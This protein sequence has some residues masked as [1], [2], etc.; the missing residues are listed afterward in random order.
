VVRGTGRGDA[1]APHRGTVASWSALADGARLSGVVRSP[2]SSPCSASL[3]TASA[4]LLAVA[5]L[6]APSAVPPSPT[7]PSPPTLPAPPP[8]SP[9]RPA[10]P[11]SPPLSPCSAVPAVT[12][13]T[14][15]LAG[16]PP[17][18]RTLAAGEVDAYEIEL[19]AGEY[20]HLRVEQLQLDVAIAVFAPGHRRLFCADSPN[21]PNGPEEVH[22][23]ADSSGR[24]RLEVKGVAAGRS[25]AYR[26]QLVVRRPARAADHDRFEAQMAARQATETGDDAAGFWEAAAKDEKAMRGLQRPDDR[27]AAAAIAYQL[28]QL[29]F[30]HAFYRDA[31]RLY[32]QYL[33]LS[34]AL[35]RR[36]EQG[37]ALNEIGQ[38][39]T[40]L[41]EPA[42]ALAAFRRAL[43]IWRQERIPKEE[44]STLINVAVLLSYHGQ[45]WEALN[46][47]ER[48][49]DLA[50]QLRDGQSEVNALNGVGMVHAM[51]GDFRR[52]RDAHLAA[53]RRLNQI[54]ERPSQQVT[55][56]FLAVAASASGDPRQALALLGQSLTLVK[57][58]DAESLRLRAVIENTIGVSQMRLHDDEAALASFGSA[59]ALFQ[60]LGLA[61][62]EAG[63]RGNIGRA[64]RQL[65]RLPAAEA[66]FRAALDRG[67]LLHDRRLEATGQLGLAEVL[68][69]GAQPED[70]LRI[71]EQGLETV[72]SLRSGAVRADL[73]TSYLAGQEELFDVVIESLMA[74]HDRQPVAGGLVH[75]ALARSEERRARRLLDELVRNRLRD[76]RRAPVAAIGAQLVKTVA[77]IDELDL[78]QRRIG[79]TAE[80]QAAIGKA[81]REKLEAASELEA[82]AAL[83]AVPVGGASPAPPRLPTP[84]TLPTLPTPPTLPTLPRLPTL[85]TPPTPPA[86]PAA[87]LGADSLLL[88]YHLAEPRSFLW[89]LAGDGR[90][91]SFELPGRQVIEERVR[92]VYA[93]DAH[94]GNAAPDWFAAG[95]ERGARLAKELGQTLLGQAASL[96]GEKRL[97]IAADG[98]LQYLPFAAL[99]D[100]DGSGNPLVVRH[101]L[102]AIPSLAVLAE[103]R[104]RAAARTPPARE[105]PAADELPRLAGTAT[106]AA[107][108]LAL[109]PGAR[110][111][112][113]SGFAAT[114]EAVTRGDLAGYRILHFAT[115]GDA[116]PQ[117][118][119]LSAIA[120]SRYDAHGTPRDG[121]LR[122]QALARLRLPADLVVLSACATAL[123]PEVERE[124]MFGLPQ[125]FLAAGATRVLVSLWNVGDRSTAELMRRFYCHLLAGGLPADA[126]LRRAQLEMWRQPRWR[127]PFYWAGFVLQGD[128][129]PPPGGRAG[130]AAGVA[131]GGAGG[132]RCDG[133]PAA[134]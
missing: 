39:Y 6:T 124:G 55:L 25:G 122:A 129:Q 93:I 95:G 133:E 116:L 26:E 101:S 92:A 46:T 102:V 64:D 107:A 118:S 59:L 17:Q 24:Y 78:A 120:L 21:G 32:Q 109:A 22:L 99:P 105:R 50:R 72:E 62:E 80:E 15:A 14:L 90:V 67:H 115:H 37:V 132:A 34:T 49:R 43:A 73:Q 48:A 103:L 81:L 86:L 12:V 126:A 44:V 7:P 71:A 77:E 27:A 53:L 98:I 56:V 45:G 84:P 108:I 16:G 87:L 88:E 68:A 1:P 4:P 128:W 114:P 29:Y 30:R 75:E 97:V 106:E 60:Q 91:Q 113:L 111:L 85:P 125:S 76:D 33:A 66:E 38:S 52:A 3:T 69:D 5:R 47:F 28:G 121:Y 104:R 96:L 112:L 20:V 119:E 23:V 61:R 110:T 36:L 10:S 79:I 89:V 65:H 131:T 127:D 31:L 41:G 54:P 13:R 9:S 134:E 94:A 58:S 51:L 70:A 40:R 42:L 130:A 8:P 11:A 2:S 18:R 35:A 100:C 123:A 63:V 74:L 117:Y 19:A 57:R 82:S 83:A